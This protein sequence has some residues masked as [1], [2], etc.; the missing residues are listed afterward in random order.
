M[1]VGNVQ[2]ISGPELKSIEYQTKSIQVEETDPIL[3]KATKLNHLCTD[4][5]DY[6]LLE[7][8]TVTAEEYA[9]LS[10]GSE[11]TDDSHVQQV[12]LSLSYY[13]DSLCTTVSEESECTA[14]V[15]VYDLNKRETKILRHDIIKRSRNPLG[16]DLKN[17]FDSLGNCCNVTNN[18]RSQ[19]SSAL[20]TT[21]KQFNNRISETTKTIEV[22]RKQPRL[23]TQLK[24]THLNRNPRK[25]KMADVQL[26]NDAFGTS[27][28]PNIVNEMKS[29]NR[30]SASTI[31]IGL[32]ADDNLVT[33][34]KN[35]IENER[36]GT[37]A[38][39]E[40]DT[41]ECETNA[42]S[43]NEEHFTTGN[44]ISA[45]ADHFNEWNDSWN[46]ENDSSVSHVQQEE[47]KKEHTNGDEDSF[48]EIIAEA[49][50][51]T[52]VTQYLPEID[53]QIHPFEHVHERHSDI[54][55]PINEHK[56]KPVI[57]EDVISLL[58]SVKALAQ[59]FT[60][61]NH[62]TEHRPEKVA[63]PKVI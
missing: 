58:P 26:M 53:V 38:N 33:A 57:E 52:A 27:L 17:P 60:E 32:N 24:S 42:D 23:V 62:I 37:F 43:S 31:N 47:R 41:H 28:D 29:E 56:E 61:Q 50:A 21:I 35:L 45:N 13:D 63:R 22:A 51:T 40:Y 16:V 11:G 14:A 3:N 34:T 2:V 44:A 5:R 9:K 6:Y 12:S 19:N 55:V 4:D 36:N 48:E 20:E 25:L 59:T 54:V 10:L 7:S 39:S 46:D 49:I 1:I 15:R 8:D 30:E 18:Q